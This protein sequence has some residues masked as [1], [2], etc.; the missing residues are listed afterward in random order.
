MKDGK[1]YKRS[2]DL[3]LLKG[4]KRITDSILAGLNAY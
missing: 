1:E 2:R 4:P 3:S